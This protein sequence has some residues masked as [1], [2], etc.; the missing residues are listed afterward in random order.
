M[1]KHNLPKIT[2]TARKY[3]LPVRSKFA[4]D[5]KIFKKYKIKTPD[6]F[7]SWHPKRKENFFNKIK[8]IRRDVTEIVCHPGYYDKNCKYPYNKQRKL[9]LKVLKSKEF[10]KI[11]KE[12]KLI[13]YHEF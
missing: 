9:E 1:T 2:R 8:N 7:I 4:E 6:E 10:G 13:N 12:F 5:R 3:N 11:I